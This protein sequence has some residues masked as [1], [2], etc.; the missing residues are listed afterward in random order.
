MKITETISVYGNKAKQTANVVIDGVD[1]ELYKNIDGEGGSFRLY[2][3][4]SGNTV[5]VVKFPDYADA[6]SYHAKAVGNNIMRP[7]KHC[8]A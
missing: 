8:K 7:A 6:K 5:T 4:E 1:Y 2:D 3:S